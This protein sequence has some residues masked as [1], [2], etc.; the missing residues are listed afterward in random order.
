MSQKFAGKVALVTGGNSG[1]GLATALAFAKEGAR[2]VITGRDQATL[3][4]AAAQLGEKVIAVR[5]DAGSVADGI[6]ARNV[7][8]TA[9]RDARRRVYQ[10]RR[11]Q[12]RSVRSGRGRD[13]GCDL[14]HQPERSVFLDQGAATTP[15]SGSRHRAQWLDQRP[16][17]HA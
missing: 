15:E 12:V 9:G 6:Q 13:V 4:K 10:C 17:W 2:V 8:A 1:I 7:V 14:Q 3:D 5:N 11:G 16:H